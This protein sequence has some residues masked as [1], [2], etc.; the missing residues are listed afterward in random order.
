[1]ASDDVL[2]V[3]FV[4]KATSIGVV[5]TVAPQRAMT[6]AL[7]RP[8][9]GRSRTTS[10]SPFSVAVENPARMSLASTTTTANGA[11]P[12][13]V[14]TTLPPGGLEGVFSRNAPTLDVVVVGPD[15]VGG[16]V[17]VGAVVVGGVEEVVVAAMVVGGALVTGVVAWVVA[18]VA[19]GAV[20][21]GAVGGTAAVVAVV[22]TVGATGEGVVAA[23]VVGAGGGGGGGGGAA[24]V[25]VLVVVGPAGGGGGLEI[26]TV[27]EALPDTDVLSSS[28]AI[29]VTTSVCAAPAG[30]V[31][32][33]SKAQT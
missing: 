6:V 22:V 7:P 20:A 18:T 14:A 10:N 23:V 2:G 12:F 27:A 26:E 15:V 32:L 5:R 25:V 31:K 16:V 28:V 33:P 19:G 30:P 3:M 24:V 29:T 8:S 11:Q 4:L 21:S 17:V 13:P 9:G 1:M